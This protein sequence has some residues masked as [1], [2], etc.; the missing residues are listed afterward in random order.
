MVTHETL[1]LLFQ[2]GLFLVALIG[3]GSYLDQ[4]K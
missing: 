3:P 2:F 1:G 4:K